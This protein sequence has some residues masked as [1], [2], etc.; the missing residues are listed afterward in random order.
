MILICERSSKKAYVSKEKSVALKKYQK[1][2]DINKLHIE[3]GHPSKETMHAATKAMG[4][5]MTNTFKTC[6]IVS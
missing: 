2:N 4:L 1:H 5:K 6:K 3:L